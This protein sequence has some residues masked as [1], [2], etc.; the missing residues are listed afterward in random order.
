[1]SGPKGRV[2]APL[3]IAALCLTFLSWGGLVASTDV[4]YTVV[5]RD[6]YGDT[7]NDGTLTITNT[8]TNVA[9]ATSTRPDNGCKYDPPGDTCAKTETACLPCG[10]YSAQQAG[11]AY[12]FEVSWFIRDAGGSTVAEAS[13][14]DSATFLGGV[15]ASCGLG[16]G[17]VSE[18]ECETCPRRK[19]SDIDGVGHCTRCEAG[20]YSRTEGATTSDTCQVCEEAGTGSSEGSSSCSTCEAGTYGGGGTACVPCPAGKYSGEVGATTSDTCQVC[21]EAGTGSSRG[22]SSCSTCEAGTY[23]GGGTACLPCNLG[24]SSKAGSKTCLPICEEGEIYTLDDNE[25]GSCITCD[26]CVPCSTCP[27]A[28]KCSDDGLDPKYYF[29]HY[30]TSACTMCKDDYMKVRI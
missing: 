25:Q 3:L 6:S 29:E 26:N 18:T 17:A 4:C 22:S 19:Y 1:M 30:E 16:S 8:E 27:Y 10:T 5:T 13:G 12:N 15:C 24:S 9:A 2:P 23:G 7:W 21:E 14:T 20:R 28:Y 11:S